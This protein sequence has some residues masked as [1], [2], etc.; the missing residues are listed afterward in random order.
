MP[1]VPAPPTPSDAAIGP[2]T[3]TRQTNT[4]TTCRAA[5]RSG[6]PV[7]VA[8]LPVAALTV[9]VSTMSAW[10]APTPTHADTHALAQA[11]ASAQ[12]SRTAATAPAR[13]RTARSTRVV[14][15]NETDC[16]FALKE[17][18]LNAGVWVTKPPAD[19]DVSDFK[20]ESDRRHQVRGTSG[21]VVYTATG[22]E[23]AGNQI[24]FSWSNP[25]IGRNSYSTEGTARSFDIQYGGGSGNHATVFPKIYN[26]S[27]Y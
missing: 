8:A 21:W 27:S 17:A 26:T 19:M 10:A 15:Q 1:T 4:V 2:G 25:F 3:E 23:R 20:S 6:R 14:L 12:T 22:C 24:K 16:K 18:G 11:P 5:R 9:A 7:T 13:I